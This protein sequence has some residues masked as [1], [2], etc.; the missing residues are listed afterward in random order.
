MK[1]NRGFSSNIGAILAAAGGAV[2]LGNIWRFPYMLGQ[3]GGGAFLIIY[4]FFVLL[5]GIPLIMSE[6]IIGRRAQSNVVGAYRKLSGGNKMWSTLGIFCIVSALM[7]YAFYSVVAGWTLNYLVL[8]CGN[9]LSGLSS[10]EIVQTFNTFTQGSFYPLL[11][12]F[13]FLSIT[14]VVVSM[15][16]QKGIE[17]FSKILMPLLFI[18]LLCMCVRSLSLE[19]AS[20]GIKFVFKPDFKKITGNSLLEALGQS[21]FSLS[22]GMG[23]MI[24]YGSY[25]QKKDNLFKSSVWIAVCDLLVAILAGLVILSVAMFSKIK[26]M[27]APNW[28]ILFYLMSLIICLQ[29]ICSPSFSLSC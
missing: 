18:L 27:M 12:Q 3:N 19:G 23:A 9:K 8:A 22:L 7:I 24:T 26:K 17:K 13:L 5:F 28:S 25:M 10:D 2:G 1:E 21:F 16:V 4:I 20:E 11:F 15:G 6:F 29:V 14:A